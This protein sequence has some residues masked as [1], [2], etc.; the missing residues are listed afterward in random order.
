MY[1]YRNNDLLEFYRF[2]K[3]LLTLDVN[4]ADS[5]PVRKGKLLIFKKVTLRI[6]D[7]DLKKFHLRSYIQ[8]NF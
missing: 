3:L 4:K 6:N 1:L 2:R 8:R 7:E 5:P